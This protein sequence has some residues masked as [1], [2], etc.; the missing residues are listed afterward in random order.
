MNSTL[1]LSLVQ[2]LTGVLTSNPNVPKNIG[3]VAASAETSLAAIFTAIQRSSGGVSLN[4]ST[5]LA[6]IA[7]VVT[8]LQA[9]PNLP[10]DVLAKIQ[11][12]NKAITSAL[13]ADSAAQ[14]VVDPSQL[15][16]IDPI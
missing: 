8:A 6:A 7:G 9:D 16:R 4:P 3:Q 10:K 15:K 5:I 14:Q 11:S 13:A 1:L 12:M 2:V